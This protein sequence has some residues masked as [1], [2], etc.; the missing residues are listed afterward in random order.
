MAS[1][2][3]IALAWLGLC[4]AQVFCLLLHPLAALLGL[5]QGTLTMVPVLSHL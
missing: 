1:L 2:G 4:Q 5:S 3:P